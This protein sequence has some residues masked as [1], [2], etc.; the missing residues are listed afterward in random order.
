[1]RQRVFRSVLI[2]GAIAAAVL[3][4]DQTTKIWVLQH[5]EAA[6][7]VLGQ[8]LQIVLFKNTG[9]AFS[10]ALPRM[11]IL[12]FTYI[13]LIIGIM[14][15]SI[16]LDLSKLASRIL[17]GIVIGGT[18]GN[19]ID[20]IGRGYVVDFIAVFK[21]PVFNIADIGLV[22]GLLGIVIF[23]GKIKRKK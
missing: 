7:P 1:M 21:Y 13:F 15:A 4:L 8:W 20:R 17:L 16:D 12:G 14:V 10:I 3:F 5:G 22:I 11:I 19:L 23:Y 6:I 18:L 9:I 2:I